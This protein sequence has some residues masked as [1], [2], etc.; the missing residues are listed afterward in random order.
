MSIPL[1]IQQVQAKATRLFSKQEIESSL[2]R[3]AGDIHLKLSQYNPVVLCVMISGLVPAGNLLPRLDFPL[4]VDYIHATRYLNKT[5]GAQIQ[6]IARPSIE[7]KDRVV[8]IVE[9]V[10]EGGLTLAAIV[11]DCYQKGASEVYTAVLLDKYGV[12]RVPGGIE[13]ADF[14][15]ISMEKGFVF[16]YGMDYRGYLRNASGIYVVAP[17][18]E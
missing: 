13:K 14:T 7:L 17:E 6:W 11:E 1:Y 9:D 16:G 8:L 10:L 15:A 5:V 18:H 4:E 2:D 12:M 3:M